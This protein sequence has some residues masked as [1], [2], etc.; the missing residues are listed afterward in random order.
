MYDI[1]LLIATCSTI[2]LKQTQTCHI[3]IV[4]KGKY[5]RKLLNKLLDFSDQVHNYN[6]ID[7]MYTNKGN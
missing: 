5:N 3:L 4:K 1:N 2:N 6:Y 7:Y